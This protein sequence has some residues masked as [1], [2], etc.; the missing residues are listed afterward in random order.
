[1]DTAGGGVEV[2]PA[3]GGAVGA[4]VVVRGSAGMEAPPGLAEMGPSPVAVFSPCAGAAQD[5]FAYNDT[6]TSNVA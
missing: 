4:T 3:G 6:A 1:M 5:I 2:W